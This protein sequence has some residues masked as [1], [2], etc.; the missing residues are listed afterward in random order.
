LC[1]AKIID[2]VP[3]AFFLPRIECSSESC[4]VNEVKGKLVLGMRKSKFID[5]QEIVIQECSDQVAVGDVPKTILVIA[6]GSAT[7]QCKPGDVIKVIGI[8][9]P[10][11][12]KFNK[13][14]QDLST[15]LNMHVAAFKITKFKRNVVEYMKDTIKSKVDTLSSK[16]RYERVI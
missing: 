8:F 10:S 6:K 5:Y 15:L 14:N 2:S 4:R 12:L 7:R 9:K 1:G 13:R 11:P 3:E 16:E